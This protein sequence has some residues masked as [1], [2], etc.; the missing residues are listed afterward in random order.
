MIKG[1]VTAVPFVEKIRARIGPSPQVTAKWLLQP[2][3][4][5]KLGGVIGVA[6]TLNSLVIAVPLGVKI[7]A[8]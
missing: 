3:I 4:D 5:G 7:R 2:T 8:T 1:F 6:L